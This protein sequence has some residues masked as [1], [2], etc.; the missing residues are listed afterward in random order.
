MALDTKYRPTGFDDVIGQSSTVR[1]LREFVG[2]GSGFRQSYLFAG[3]HGSGKTTLGRILA[4]ALLCDDPPG[5]NPCDNCDS[6]LDIL[7]SGSSAD[8]VE[9]DAATNSGKDNIRK[10]VEQIQYSSFSGK[11]RIYL[12]DEAHQLSRDALDALLKPMEDAVLGTEDKRLVCIFCTTEPERMRATVVSR[13]APTFVIRKAATDEIVGRLSWVCD[14]EGIPYDPEALTLVAEYSEA[15]IRDALKAVEGVSMVG[16]IST[17]S[18]SEYLRLDTIS[19]VM[20]LLEAI[21]GGDVR[22]ALSI[23]GSLVEVASPATLYGKISDTA[24][25]IYAGGLGASPWPSWW[26]SARARDMALSLGPRAG[27]IASRFA[28]K[29]GRVS[30]VVFLCDVAA[31]SRES[32][33]PT[34]EVAAPPQVC[35]VPPKTTSQV[36]SGRGGVGGKI[37]NTVEFQSE[38]SVVGGSYLDPRGVNKS[39]I[40]DAADNNRKARGSE[41]KAAS[42]VS[43]PLM[44]PGDFARIVLLRLSELRGDID[45]GSER[46]NDMGDPRTHKDG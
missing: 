22:E 37:Y 17:E 15:H 35:A 2:T 18:V 32:L 12:F 30:S 39:G 31:A 20:S 26:D 3:P 1:I 4:R 36:G 43:A 11:R 24:I 41:K 6:C 8:F 29:P 21:G 16:H 34:V 38:P 13:C 14:A 23:A 5:G 10:I 9:V 40:T 7:R 27:V 19:T 45:A 28:S 44:R 25:T 46:R 33:T 42:P